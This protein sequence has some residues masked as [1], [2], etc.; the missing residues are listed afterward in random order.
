VLRLF[1]P[2]RFFHERIFV[3]SRRPFL[4]NILPQGHWGIR[5][6]APPLSRPHVRDTSCPFRRSF[7]F[8]IVHRSPF[9]S[10]I[11]VSAQEP[12]KHF[13]FRLGHRYLC[14]SFLPA[15]TCPPPHPA[16]S[17]CHKFLPAAAG[18]LPLKQGTGDL[19]LL[20]SFEAPYH[21]NAGQSFLKTA[22]GGLRSP[23]QDWDPILLFTHWVFPLSIRFCPPLKVVI[24]VS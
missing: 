14:A 11:D 22:G 4:P 2:A 13:P 8:R 10:G 24:A 21:S 15:K 16:P 3:A 18:S 7:F 17:A 20:G 5:H 12:R 23:Q 19:R 1:F 9:V 6:M